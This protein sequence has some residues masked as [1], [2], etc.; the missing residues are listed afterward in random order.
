MLTFIVPIKSKQVSDSWS[1]FCELVERTFKSICN[2]TD[3]NFNLVAVCHEIPT[4]N[5]TH[6]NIHY[7]QV[8][9][10]PPIRDKSESDES[11]NKRREVDKG[12]KIEVGSQY[13]KEKFNTTYVMIV[14]SDDYVSN[15][16]SSFVNSNKEDIS[17]WYIK[18]GY[19]HF[20]GKS[21]LFATF[22]FSYL[23]GS[24]IIIKPK[25]LDYFFEVDPI[26]YFDHRLTELNN[27][28]KLI[29]LPFYGGIYSMANGENHLMS[30]SNIKRFNNH[31]GWFSS[32]GI[33][34]IYNKLKNY[35]FRFITKRIR[36]EF[37]FY[38]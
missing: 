37:N 32:E 6:K 11:I 8:D 1:G 21:F 2:Q 20:D 16:I 25:L 18:N 28:I 27:Q 15:Q 4:I 5:F 34:R 7:V 24:S 9:F 35:R 33:M 22:K 19:L 10:E 30:F 31:K 3:Q 26:L 17:G 14:D 36:E 13:A 12:K 23:C 29:P 38:N